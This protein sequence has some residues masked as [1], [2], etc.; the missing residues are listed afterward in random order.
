MEGP[1]G[2]YSPSAS[3]VSTAQ[4]FV[5]GTETDVHNSRLKFYFYSKLDGTEELYYTIDQNSPH[6][7]TITKMMDLR[8]SSQ[9]KQY[10]VLCK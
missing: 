5:S 10:E 8:Y 9:Y 1:A 4:D 7:G 2:S 3:F 6:Y